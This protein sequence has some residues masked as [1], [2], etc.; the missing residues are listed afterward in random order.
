VHPDRLPDD[1]P[2]S[3]QKRARIVDWL[4]QMS[5]PGAVYTYQRREGDHVVTVT[6]KVSRRNA[7]RAMRTLA[8]YQRQALQQQ[9]ADRRVQREEAESYRLKDY[10]TPVVELAGDRM[11]A[12][13]RRRGLEYAAE[14]DPETCAAIMRQAEEE[15]KAYGIDGGPKERKPYR[16]RPTWVI[17]QAVQD[18]VVARLVDLV[19]PEGR[20]A[21]EAKLRER[22]IAASV[23]AQWDRLRAEQARAA[24]EAEAHPVF[25]REQALAETEAL[26][27]ERLAERERERE[28]GLRRRA[29]SEKRRAMGA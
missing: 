20:E 22:F 1:A 28:E 19:D 21:Q 6:K 29:E 3:A 25:D 24:H 7:L 17:S 15:L 2:L 27:Q 16:A 9:K 10:V 13:A 8:T 18:A 5:R 4:A 14:L 23:L 26:M 11:L 12:E